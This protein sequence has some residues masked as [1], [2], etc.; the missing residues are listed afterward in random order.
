MAKGDREAFRA[1][2]KVLG[3][4]ESDKKGKVAD[5][6]PKPAK[7]AIVDKDGKGQKASGKAGDEPGK[8]SAP[9]RSWKGRERR[10]PKRK[11][12]S[13]NSTAKFPVANE[14]DGNWRKAPK[15]ALADRLE[16]FV[17]HASEM[18]ALER[19]AEACTAAN[20][21][22]QE[23]SEYPSCPV[24]LPGAENTP[25][26]TSVGR[27]GALM[28]GL[29]LVGA[30]PGPEGAGTRLLNFRPAAGGALPPSAINVGDRVAIAVT[31]VLDYT[32]LYDESPAGYEV[33]GVIQSL[34]PTRNEVNLVVDGGSVNQRRLLSKGSFVIVDEVL[35]GKILR[36]V[37]VP[38]AVTYERQL[39]ALKKLANVPN[40]RTGPPAM[41]IVRALF[42][43]QRCPKD[44]TDASDPASRD[45]SPRTDGYDKG[46]GFFADAPEVATPKAARIVSADDLP[47]L[48]TRPVAKGGG[49]PIPVDFDPA[50]QL[51]V[52][53][54]LTKTAPV[55]WI[56]GPPGT[57]KTGVV[58]EIIR[59]AVASGQ[60][61][62][63]CA[64]SN[65]AVDNLVERLA[66]L[67]TANELDAGN[68][69]DFVRIGAP[70]RISSA[71]LESSLDA[72]I[73][74]ETGVFF[75]AS[76]G[77]KKEI[78]LAKRQG[79]EKQEELQK[80]KV[81]GLGDKIS[82]KNIE[83]KLGN[84]R[85]EQ[86]TLAKSGKKVR[87]NAERE[88][89]A[90]VQVVLATAVGAG[91]ENIQRLPAFDI[92]ILDEA[93]Q[94]TEPA[95]WIPMVRSKRAVLVG[96]PCQ[97]APLVRSTEASDG[98]LA[99]PLMARV[100]QNIPEKVNSQ[101]APAL[102]AANAYLS[103]GVL[104]CV[105]T[106]QYRSNQLISDWA[107]QEMYGGR[108]AASER[109]AS[110]LLSQMPGVASTPATN[111]PLLLL[112]TRTRAG[113]LLTGC[114]EVSESEMAARERS[115]NI[116]STS[117]DEDDGNLPVSSS[118]SLVNEGEAYAVMMHV[119]GLLGA[120]LAPS[121]IAVQSPYA[122]QVR[123]IR[124]KLA[125]V[126]ARGAAPGADL[127]E[128]A[129]VDSFQGREAEAVVISTVR[130]NDKQSVG[131]LADVRRAN[132]AVTRARRHVCIVGDSVT[133][134]GD[135]FLNRL[136]SHM[137]TNGLVATANEF[138]ELH[139]RTP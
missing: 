89:L 46:V 49:G 40:S 68:V 67:N 129:S 126:A 85:R 90:E 79:W 78:D 11:P 36:F 92:V 117:R 45:D 95:A 137:R 6:K 123:L 135:P 82:A 9:K 139:Q 72:R 58:I 131:F 101:K 21:L 43:Q 61:V 12:S 76:R 64:P 87:A 29:M 118:S 86:R 27:A 75:D 48:D 121:D 103:S 51:A 73:D 125:D 127:V 28:E 93:A 115:R 136:M 124:T 98:G 84:L 122:A 130:S 4:E 105:L 116:F 77:R 96:D 41:D 104:G 74:R 24:V 47:P 59:R 66:K 102:G 107:S 8:S 30:A 94:A 80:G 106:T 17:K 26:G 42:A 44:S 108:L 7:R 83:T 10:M 91:A 57:G 22:L 2:L 33:E 37:R 134:G 20:L 109:V 99:T 54:A 81:K 110:R 100:S 60:R 128:V 97:L 31:G 34:E 113:M 112:D 16:R 15:S 23:Q 39:A 32:D 55:V 5:R 53:I 119:A 62:L 69:I 88:I 65:A 52:R 133:V 50:Q 56:Q 111:A 13:K 25:E 14:N 18:L 1:A 63:A 138:G 3:N 132:V 35:A 71:A 38:D 70:E 114:S 19:E 120:G